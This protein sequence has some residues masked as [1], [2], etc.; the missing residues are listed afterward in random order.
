M[1]TTNFGSH[2][3]GFW[4]IYTLCLFSWETD[5]LFFENFDLSPKKSAQYGP[6]LVK[7]EMAGNVATCNRPASEYDLRAYLLVC[8]QYM[9]PQA[10]MS[11]KSKFEFLHHIKK[12]AP[13]APEKYW[14]FLSFFNSKKSYFSVLLNEKIWN[15]V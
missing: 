1:K 3:W 14:V 8:Y 5:K 7:P 15:S 2:P 4:L 6:M 11:I 12:N 9:A 10:R 13:S